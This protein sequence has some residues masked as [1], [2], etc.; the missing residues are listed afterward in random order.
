[1]LTAQAR[2][3]LKKLNSKNGLPPNALPPATL[4]SLGELFGGSI[5]LAAA[6]RVE[7]IEMRGSYYYGEDAYDGKNPDGTAKLK[8][9]AKRTPHFLVD[10]DIRK[11]GSS[12]TRTLRSQ[13]DLTKRQARDLLRDVTRKIALFVWTNRDVK[14]PADES[15]GSEI[16]PTRSD[17][18]SEED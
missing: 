9:G 13:C 11:V 15:N 10:I 14:L 16:Q 7:S 4:L 8:P 12:D 3:E 2:R 6:R 1:M 17:R 5:S 18:F